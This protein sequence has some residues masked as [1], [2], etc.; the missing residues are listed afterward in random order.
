M[1]VVKIVKRFTL[2]LN[3]VQIGE[4]PDENGKLVPVFAE[5]RKIEFLPGIYDLP[6]EQAEH[7]YLKCHVEGYVDPPPP[8]G[9]TQYAAQMLKVEQAVRMAEPVE[10]QGQ[11]PEQTPSPEGVER[12]VPV[13]YFAGNPMPEQ[14]QPRPSWLPPSPT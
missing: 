13:H 1:P 14:P 4:A 10:E 2:Q 3:P 12:A 7:W 9:T 8:D 11:K 6:D 5:A